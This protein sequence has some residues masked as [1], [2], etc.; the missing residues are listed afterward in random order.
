MA[1]LIQAYGLLWKADDVFWGAGSHRGAIYGV[2]WRRRSADPIDFRDQIG[3]YVLYSGTQIVYVGQAG[4]GRAK[5]IKRLKK[6]RRDGLAGRWDSFSWFGLRRALKKGRLSKISQRARPSLAT[7]LNQT[8]AILIAA[9][10]PLLNKQGGRFGKGKRY[11]QVRDDRLGLTHD[12][13]IEKI[14][15][16]L[17]EEAAGQ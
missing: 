17:E 5:L 15:N 14:L 3:I 4:S 11:A 8:E 16:H 6:H 1:D 2:P 10:E 7:T 9:T 12:Q 13:K